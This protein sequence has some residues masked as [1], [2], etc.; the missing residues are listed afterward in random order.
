MLEQDEEHV[1]VLCID[2]GDAIGRTVTLR[3]DGDGREVT[4]P[5]SA[6]VVRQAARLLGKTALAST[7]WRIWSSGADGAVDRTPVECERLR[8]FVERPFLEVVDEMRAKL[9]AAGVEVDGDAW[10]AEV[11]DEAHP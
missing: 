8:A 10:L 9:I 1:T 6:S 2:I 3:L 11:H 7:V 4:F 5:C